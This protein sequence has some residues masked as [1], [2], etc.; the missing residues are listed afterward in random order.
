MNWFERLTGFKEETPDQV[1]SNISV[2]G[3]CLTSR[4]NGATYRHGRLEVP[5][6]AELRKRTG[7]PSGRKG[8][9]VDQISADVRSLHRDPASAGALF[10]VASQFNLLEMVSPNVTPEMG[11]GIYEND[12]TQGPAC[13]IAAGAGTIYRNYFASV[14][15]STGQSASNQIDCLQDLGGE[16]GNVDDRLWRMSNGYA[17]ATEQGLHEISSRLRSA[18]EDELDRLRGLLR[19]GVHSGTEV[20]DDNAG[21]TVS[22]AYCSALPV[23]YTT[24]SPEL[25]EPFARLALEAAYECTLRTALLNPQENGADRVFLT[26]LGG[27]VFGNKMEWIVDAMERAVRLVRD[28]HL[29]V[30]IVNRG[31]A[32]SE[33]QE[34]IKRIAV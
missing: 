29:K 3:E 14:N 25:W 2:D 4:I 31:P 23:A 9:S 18:D 34:M 6:L 26:Y 32:R 30:T 15:G 24:H 27:G 1:R 19:I 8:I 10:Q 7:P 20:T 11:V 28:H 12:P 33:I 21:H 22:Q 17:L 16:L 5:S 13:A